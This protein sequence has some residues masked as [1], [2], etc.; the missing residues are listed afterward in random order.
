MPTDVDLERGKEVFLRRMQ[1]LQDQQQQK[2]QRKERKRRARAPPPPP[3]RPPQ[4]PPPPRL[5]RVAVAQPPPPPRDSQPS[6]ATAASF[7]EQLRDAERRRDAKERSELE[8]LARRRREAALALADSHRLGTLLQAW[9]EA[10]RLSKRSVELWRAR[11]VLRQCMRC[12]ERRV[13]ASR[14][15]RLG[16]EAAAVARVRQRRQEALA[17]RA[18]S[19]WRD[20]AH[21]AS[22]NRHEVEARLMERRRTTA[23]AAWR[24]AARDERL[25]RQAVVLRSALRQW[26]GAVALLREEARLLARAREVL[27]C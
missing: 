3:P 9:S 19:G 2:Q 4:P 13:A 18:Y 11:W 20:A 10:S 16:S 14:W 25:A 1:A 5:P 8:R 15:V 24:R 21:Q 22:G 6:K 27:R 7:V 12:F 17:R 26:R 23:L